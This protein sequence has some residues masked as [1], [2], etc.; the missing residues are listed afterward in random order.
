MSEDTFRIVVTAAVLLASLAFVV[1][2]GIVFAMYRLTRKIQVKTEGFVTRAEPV[3][4]KIEPL[5]DKAGPVIEKAGPVVEKVGPAIDTI[6]A[7]VVRLGPVIDRCIPVVDQAKVAVE[8]AGV[9]IQNANLV[10]V[11]ANEILLDTR[12]R[13]ADISN[14]AATIV[15]TGREQVERV[16]DLLHDAGDRAR[17]R[18]EQ[19]DHTVETTVQQ[20]GTRVQY[21]E[22]GGAATCP[23]GQRNCRRYLCS[24]LHPCEGSQEQRRLRHA[25]RRNVYLAWRSAASLPSRVASSDRRGFALLCRCRCSRTT[26]AE[27]SPAS[28]GRSGESRDGAGR[29]PVPQ[30]ARARSDAGR[31]ADAGSPGAPFRITA[32]A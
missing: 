25:R 8:R 27:H 1:Q 30:A 29:A 13:I 28:G 7:T 3:F 17:A 26:A 23:R 32:P 2:A 21:G 19:V 4:A 31:C 6:R 9:L 12:P 22:K 24:R 20:I 15:R 14:E 16:G 11:S 10:A 5:L 18:L